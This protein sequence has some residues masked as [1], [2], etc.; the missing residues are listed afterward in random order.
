MIEVKN[1]NKSFDGK[2]VLKN[3]SATFYKGKVNQIIGQS[4]GGKTVL[5]KS[6]IGLFPIDSGEVLYNGRNI[7]D[8]SKIEIKGLRKEIGM[9]FQG[10]ALFDSQRVIENVMFPLVMF[11]DKDPA[12]ARDR[13]EFCLTRVDIKPQAF[14]NGNRC[15]HNTYK[16]RRARLAGFATRY[17]LCRQRS[18]KRFCICL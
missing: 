2:Q 9:L 17:I 18:S 6:I 15:K 11:S 10:S 7:A 8:M 1:L 12:E 4:G 3:I 13:A 16:K 5:M 14:D